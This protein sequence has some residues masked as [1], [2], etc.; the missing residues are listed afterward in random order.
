[1][2]NLERVALEKFDSFL[3]LICLKT[4]T[5]DARMSSSSSSLISSLMRL[6]G[7]RDDLPPGP[8]HRLLEGTVSVYVTGGVGAGG[9]LWVGGVGTNT[10][11]HA[12]SYCMSAFVSY[13]FVMVS[14]SLV[15]HSTDRK[16]RIAILAQAATLLY[17]SIR[18][19][20]AFAQ[21]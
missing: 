18:R 20:A 11:I 10:Y 5:K 9:S 1:M 6:V 19:F 8:Y 4:K 2:I 21:T 14:V 16:S 17:N 3:A 13:V 15:S 7:G 12:L